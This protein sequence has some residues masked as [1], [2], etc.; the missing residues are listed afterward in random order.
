M[1]SLGTIAQV[2]KSFYVGIASVTRWLSDIEPKLTCNK[3]ATKICM[4]A[5]SKDVQDYPDAYQ[6]E[7]AYH[8]GVTEKT[9]G[10]ALG[11]VAG[12]PLSPFKNK[13]IPIQHKLV[14][15]LC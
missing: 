7:R 13:N 1:P 11:A 14:L 4:Q 2:V 6:Y 9:V 12:S 15:I 10:H 8:L 5:L 3:P